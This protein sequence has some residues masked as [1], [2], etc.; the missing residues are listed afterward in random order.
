MAQLYVWLLLKKKNGA[1]KLPVAPVQ[2]SLLCV[3]KVFSMY[4]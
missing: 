3:H 2:G 4:D 1:S